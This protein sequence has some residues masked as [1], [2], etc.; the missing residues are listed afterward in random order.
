MRVPSRGISLR[1]PNE[2]TGEKLLNETK[3]RRNLPNDRWKSIDITF[4]RQFTASLHFTRK[5]SRALWHYCRPIG[6][7]DTRF[8]S[9]ISQASP[10][11]DLS[12]PRDFAPNHLGFPPIMRKIAMRVRAWLASRRTKSIPRDETNRHAVISN[13]CGERR[14]RRP[15]TTPLVDRPHQ[16]AQTCTHT[17]TYV[18]IFSLFLPLRSYHGTTLR[19]QT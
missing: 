19:I 4:H 11:C 16:H 12:P 13:T 15:Q 9:Q 17:H 7:T 14:P 5:R 1:K 6:L 3:L 10:P 18:R 2:A 8:R